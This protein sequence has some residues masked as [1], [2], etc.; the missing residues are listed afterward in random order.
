MIDH[1]VMQDL[2]VASVVPRAE[3][4]DL[5]PWPVGEPLALFAP[6][7]IALSLDLPDKPSALL[8]I[9]RLAQQRGGPGAAEIAACLA[10]REARDSTALG[11]GAALPHA[12]VP[13]LRAPLAVYLRSAQGIRFGAAD[14]HPV[15]DLLALLVPRPATAAHF[16]L[17]GRLRRRL[18]HPELRRALARTTCPHE[19]CE[20]FSR[21]FWT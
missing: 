7:R 20:L 4:L 11:R 19:V 8:A 17:L 16:D 5:P 10:R 21:W 14:G 3:P 2:A 12:H 15:H 9:G 1:S 18:L 6:A 13:R